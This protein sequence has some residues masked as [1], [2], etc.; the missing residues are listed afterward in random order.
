MSTPDLRLCLGRIGPEAS[1][2]TDPCD[3]HRTH[4]LHTPLARDPHMARMVELFIHRM[5]E[6]IEAL[7]DAVEESDADAL[8][9]LVRRLKSTAAGYGF[10]P[11]T[12]QAA[13]VERQIERRADW[14]QVKQTVDALIELCEQAKAAP[15]TADDE[16]DNPLPPAA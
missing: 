9:A 10:E 13:R 12:E 11:I 14:R 16:D 7:H 3:K 4:A 1:E 5:P 15:P 6:H 2:P 8:E